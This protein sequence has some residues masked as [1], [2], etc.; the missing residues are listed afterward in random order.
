MPSIRIVYLVPDVYSLSVAMMYVL[1]NTHRG[2]DCPG[3]D[4][5]M[6]KEMAS[7][8]SR[9]NL[10]GKNIRMLDVFVDQSCMLQQTNRDHYCLFVVEAET[11][12]G[13]PQ[14][15]SPMQIDVRPMIRWPSFPL[16]DEPKGSSA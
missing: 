6:M 14:L 2:A 15:F 11:P 9:E 10:A 12:S 13:L 8:F 7:K 4:P 5:D 16:K 3:K 1:Y